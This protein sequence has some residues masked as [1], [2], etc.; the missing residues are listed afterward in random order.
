M[1]TAHDVAAY[2]LKK[3][4]SMSAMK[5]QKL[6]Y[7]SQAWHL[8]WEDEPLFADHI[9]AWANGPVAPAL[10]KE[11]RGKFTVGTWPAGDAGRLRPS[12]RSSVDAVLEY[13]GDKSAFWLSELTHREAPWKDAREGVGPGEPC[14]NEIK[15]AAMAEF[16]GSLV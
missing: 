6:V 9:Q 14:S 11:H 2:I 10:Y 4:G 3:R 15:K 13:Y 16:Y 5:L 1:A 12:Q 8:V 7:Y